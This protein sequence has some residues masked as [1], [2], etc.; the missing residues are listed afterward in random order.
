LNQI[1]LGS[2][3]GFTKQFNVAGGVAAAFYHGDNVIVFQIFSAAAFHTLAPISAP[4][5]PANSGWNCVAA[6]AGIFRFIGCR[7]HLQSSFRNLQCDFP[8]AFDLGVISDVSQT[9]QDI[10]R[11][12]VC[13]ARDFASRIF[14]N[15]DISSLGEAAGNGS[16]FVN[17]VIVHAFNEPKTRQ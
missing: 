1:T 17:A 2:I 9:L 12:A 15:L 13:R 10:Q 16:Q 14:I 4:D 6:C 5:F 8:V 7:Q 3:T 11:R